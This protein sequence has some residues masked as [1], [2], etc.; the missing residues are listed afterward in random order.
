MMET[1][2]VNIIWVIVSES[3]SEVASA[4]IVECCRASND[5]QSMKSAFSIRS[6]PVFQIRSVER[7]HS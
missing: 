2:F 6:E 5:T 3:V 1:R 7:P 4:V